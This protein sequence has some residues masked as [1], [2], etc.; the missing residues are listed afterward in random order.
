[1]PSHQAAAKAYTKPASMVGIRPRNTSSTSRCS[2]LAARAV[3]PPQGTMLITVLVSSSITA[4]INGFIPKR[5]YTGRRA[6]T[7]TSTVVEPSPSSEM[8]D[9]SAAVPKVMRSG[10]SP[11]QRTIRFTAGSNRPASN[12]TAK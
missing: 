4:K 6:V 11:T 8:I 2:A 10:S 9:A 7:T 3:G 12:I 5:R 1:M